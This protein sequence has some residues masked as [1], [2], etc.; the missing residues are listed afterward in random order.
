MRRPLKATIPAAALAA[1]M[2]ALTALTACSGPIGDSGASDMAESAPGSVDPGYTDTESGETFAPNEAVDPAVDPESTFAVDV[3]T[4]SYDFARRS[5]LDGELPPQDQVRPEEFVNSFDYDYPE[6][7]GN[8]FGVHLETV[9]LP[10]W[11]RSGDASLALRVGLQTRTVPDSE[12]ADVNLTFVIDVSGSME[13]DDRIGIV[14]DS[15]QMLVG[16]LRPSD[17]VAIVTYETDS[18]VLL[19]MTEVGDGEEI[20]G[21][22]DDL[23][24]RGSTNMQAGLEDGYEIAAESFD[25]ER[26]N[27]VI[28]LSDGE[29]NVGLTEHDAMLEEIGGEI[30]DG[31]TLLTVGVGDSYNQELLEQL[32]DNGDGWAVYFASAGE[33][34]EVFSERLTSTLGVTAEDAKIQVTF[35]PETVADYRLIGFE[36]RAL[37]DDEFEDDSVD[38][39]EVGPGHSVTALYAISTT[40]ESGEYA[41]VAVRWT[42]PETGETGTA[43]A[44]AGSIV[45]L[46][47]SHTANVALVAAAFAEVLRG[48]AEFTCADLLA[49]AEE[50][51]AQSEYPE[52]D[53]LV[54]LIAIAADLGA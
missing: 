33:A 50:L 24:A 52:V 12:R 7:E 21:A 1:A 45:T 40:G 42:D 8:G 6:P 17:A 2:T 11:Y 13:A 47:P 49:D 16:E 26:D 38:A 30:A 14:R 48:S 18:E 53:E 27:R 19:E 4:A 23:E 5:L 31:I 37:E 29:A 35:D 15:L 22:I 44:T 54:E 10:E 36:N 25:S 39:G 28:L 3:D 32:A 34:E 46:L 20:G 41:S 43:E 51:A 9:E